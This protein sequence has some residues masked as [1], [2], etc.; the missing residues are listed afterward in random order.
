MQD[1]LKTL[2]EV[3]SQAANPAD[4]RSKVNENLAIA[5]LQ[6]KI[7]K[8]EASF[9]TSP[10]SLDMV[11][12][13]NSQAEELKRFQLTMDVKDQVIPDLDCLCRGS[14]SVSRRSLASK[15]PSINSPMLGKP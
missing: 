10:E 2:E 9:G 13:L 11:S 3:L 5:E 1:R 7:Q 15:L 6:S 12:R 8:Y 4:L 14:Y